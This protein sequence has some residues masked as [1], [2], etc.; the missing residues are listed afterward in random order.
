MT[1]PLVLVIGLLIAQM[2]SAAGTSNDLFDAVK[3]GDLARVRQLIARGVAVD[4]VDRRGFTP[5]LWASAGGNLAVV[6]QLIESGATVDARA[7]DGLSA[8]MLASANGFTDV[9]RA[10]IRRG[11]NVNAVRD[12][13]TARQLATARGRPDV[14]ALLEEAERLGGAL[15]KAAA[16][17]NDTGVRQALPMEHPST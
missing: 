5:L 15:L 16:E 10:L 9:A 3:L 13:L 7:N 4:A 17:G 12:G 8:L 11:A 6:N 1:F 2:P 14:A